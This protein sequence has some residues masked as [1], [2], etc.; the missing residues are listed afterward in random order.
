MN[1]ATKVLGSKNK[2]K[3]RTIIKVASMCKKIPKRKVKCS[4]DDA[5]KIITLPK[6]H[7]RAATAANVGLYF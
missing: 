7:S 2:M 1:K 4:F 5:G 6:L 3:I